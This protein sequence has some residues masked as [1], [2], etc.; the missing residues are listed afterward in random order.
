VHHFDSF[1]PASVP[2][3]LE[4]S[5]WALS[6]DEFL[7]SVGTNCHRQDFNGTVDCSSGTLGANPYEIRCDD[8]R[9]DKAKDIH[10]RV[11]TALS[12]T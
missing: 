9:N 1:R 7:Q 11:I 5:R 6:S 4:Q 8:D 12:P 10:E 2:D 3:D